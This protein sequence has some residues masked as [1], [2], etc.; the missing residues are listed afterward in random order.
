MYLISSTSKL[1]FEIIIRTNGE[2]SVRLLSCL[3]SPLLTSPVATRDRGKRQENHL[4]CPA[5]KLKEA[6]HRPASASAS[7]ENRC[8]RYGVP[9]YVPCSDPADSPRLGRQRRWHLRLTRRRSPE[10]GGAPIALCPTS[11]PARHVKCEVV[12]SSCWFSWRGE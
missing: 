4:G 10:G 3:A 6:L 1:V 11:F 2:P 8:V 9:S 7:V 5:G 12:G